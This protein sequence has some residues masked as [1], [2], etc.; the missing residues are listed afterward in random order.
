MNGKLITGTVIIAVAVIVVATVMMPALD[1]ANDEIN[2]TFD[3]TSTN[4][5]KMKIVESATITKEA[6][7][8]TSVT[9]NDKTVDLN[10]AA[11]AIVLTDTFVINAR[12]TNFYVITTSAS[13]VNSSTAFTATIGSGSITYQIGTATPV[14]LSYSGTLLVADPDGDYVNMASGTA[15]L[16]DPDDIYGWSWTNNKLYVSEGEDCTVAGTSGAAAS[17]GASKLNQYE[18]LYNVAV[19]NVKLDSSGDNVSPVTVIV[20]ASV[21][22][23]MT[24]SGAGLGPILFVMPVIVILAII[25]AVIGFAIT[26]SR[27]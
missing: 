19:G 10:T 3:N 22:A 17:I 16:A 5:I 27:E 11:N 23:S 1:M 21:E 7:S 13:N 9:I 14:T 26:R 8:A 24:G 20:P 4:G 18:S 25:V 15:Y 12:T 2:P 6:G